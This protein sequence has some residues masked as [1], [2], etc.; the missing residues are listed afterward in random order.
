MID[1]GAASVF[2][3]AGKYLERVQ[4]ESRDSGKELQT[5]TGSEE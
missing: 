2:P 4:P 1:S 3:D 5:K